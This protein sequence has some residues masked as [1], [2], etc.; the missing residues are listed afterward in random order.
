MDSIKYTLPFLGQ[1]EVK[2]YD[3]SVEIYSFL[4]QHNQI[5]RLKSLNQLGIISE[6]IQTAHH[7]KFEYIFFQLYI[8]EKL[9]E[10]KG[11]YPINRNI[12]R[13]INGAEL[14]KIWAL[15]LPIGHLPGTFPVEKAVLRYCSNS[16]NFRESFLGT[17]KEKG[18]KGHVDGLITRQNV[19]SFYHALTFL[20]LS[21]YCHN[22][23]QVS[24]CRKASELLSLYCCN[25]NKESILSLKELF[26]KIRK[27]SYVV[28]DSYYTG[29]RNIL[30]VEDLG[31][32]SG[33]IPNQ[34]FENL[35][36]SLDAYLM[37]QIYKNKECTIAE[38][39][40][41]QGFYEELKKHRSPKYLIDN[42]MY[43]K[44]DAD[45]CDLYSRYRKKWQI[46]DDL[47]YELLRIDTN[48]T[49]VF[50]QEDDLDSILSRFIP[51]RQK[52]SSVLFDVDCLPGASKTS[53]VI[54]LNRLFRFKRVGLLPNLI[55][56]ALVECFRNEYTRHSSI[57]KSPEIKKS[58]AI[59]LFIKR[60]INEGN[61]KNIF[62]ALFRLAFNEKI[63]FF[64]M[65][66]RSSVGFFNLPESFYDREA[67]LINKVFEEN[68]VKDP[69]LLE[70]NK[71]INIIKNKNKKTRLVIYTGNIELHRDRAVKSGL[72]VGEIDGALL[73]VI[74]TSKLYLYLLEAKKRTRSY[75]ESRKQLSQIKRYLGEQYKK[76]SIVSIRRL[77][78]NS[79]SSY[80]R[81]RLS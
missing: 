4:E 76:R 79:K 67:Y 71:L 50:K 17:I 12:I 63:S 1:A 52:R 60:Q 41:Y 59:H 31:K 39:I 25:T 8:T 2:L 30:N 13:K 66:E 74:G 75:S 40:L 81:L 21:R 49:T 9:K 20:K 70:L 26:V 16:S 58:P 78:R 3:E 5:S 53:I 35:I 61:F 65:K 44:H 24:F 36:R 64:R 22:K 48:R 27:F 37:N 38:I 51:I 15:L 10:L 68:Q 72:I 55:R 7:P 62:Y 57:L 73:V 69:E 77:D 45:I 11:L 29:A 6:V 33:L 54:Y 34:H 28:L 43:A 23:T 19:Y 42:Y 14:L 46:N 80:L 32:L 47:Y 18:I 56:E